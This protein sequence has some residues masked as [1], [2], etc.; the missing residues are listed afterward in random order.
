MSDS[1]AASGHRD[2]SVKFWSIRDHTLLHE[3][4]NVHDDV[5]S[6]VNYM[7]YDGNTLIT[8]SKD[9]TVKLVDIRMLKVLQTY[10]NEHY[11]NTSD[12][13]Q[14]GVSPA[15]RYLALGSKNGKLSIM[16]IQ[17][18]KGTGGVEDIFV[19]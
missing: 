7:P 16:D 11:Y 5:V 12:T 17:K 1:V 13:S 9:H 3:V 10:E 15:G 19:K 18:D 4:K 6:S 2:G 8:S 14:I